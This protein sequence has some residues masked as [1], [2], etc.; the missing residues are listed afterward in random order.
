MDFPLWRKLMEDQRHAFNDVYNVFYND[1]RECDFSPFIKQQTAGF[2]TNLDCTYDYSTADWRDS[3]V[4]LALKHSTAEWVLFT[5]QDFYPHDPAAFYGNVF[6]RAEDFDV[7]GFADERGD[8]PWRFGIR[9]HPAFLLVRRSLI[10][11]TTKNFA[12]NEGFAPDHFGRFADELLAQAPRYASLESLGKL[13]ETHWTH[14]QG[15][16]NNYFLVDQEQPPNFQPKEFQRYVELCLDP[17]IVQDPRFLGW[18]KRC[19]QACR[20]IKS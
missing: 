5:E 10:D 3:C 14:W 7:I 15:V 16:V 8:K 20:R 13:P 18:S 12:H 2:V 1:N 9:L 17:T 11:Q 6:D 4:N 19:L